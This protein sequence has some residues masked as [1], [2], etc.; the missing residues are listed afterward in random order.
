MFYWLFTGQECSEKHILY[1]IYA[2][3]LLFISGCAVSYVDETS[4]QW[5]VIGFVN[6]ELPTEVNNNSNVKVDINNAGLL[7][8]LTPHQ[9]SLSLGYSQTS[10][11]Y[12]GNQEGVFSVGES[13]ATSCEV[14]S[15]GEIK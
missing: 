5:K 13:Q 8:Y 12:L 15:Q 7:L 3:L 6:M 14:K 2:T 11:I 9:N 1:L 10:T 4:G